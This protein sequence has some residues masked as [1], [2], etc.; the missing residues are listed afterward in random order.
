MP[1]LDRDFYQTYNSRGLEIFS[2]CLDEDEEMILSKILP[3]NLSYRILID[4]GRTAAR[5]YRVMGIP[6]NLIIDKKGIIRYREI[7]YDPDAMRK[8]IEELL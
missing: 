1:L 4:R 2:I 3:L 7:G 6:L 5:A 8:L